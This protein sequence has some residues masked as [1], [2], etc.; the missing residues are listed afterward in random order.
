MLT[1]PKCGYD[2]DGTTTLSIINVRKGPCKGNYCI[3][4]IIERLVKDM[5]KMVEKVE[6]PV[7]EDNQAEHDSQ[8]DWR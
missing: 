3:Y 5:P 2:T 4:C 8:A 6:T 7:E 1:C